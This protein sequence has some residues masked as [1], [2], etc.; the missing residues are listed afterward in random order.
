M[1]RNFLRFRVG[2][3]VACFAGCAAALASSNEIATVSNEVAA[4]TNEVVPVRYAVALHGDPKYPRGFK[5]FDYVNADA[6]KGGTLH[7][8]M[9]GTFDCL[10][11]FILRGR[12]APGL[13]L[14]YDTLFVSSGDEPYTVYGLIA[15]SMEFPKDR[16]WVI[17]N[18]RPEARWHDGAPITAEDVAFTFNVRREKGDPGFKFYYSS[19]SSVDVLGPRRVRFNIKPG[20]ASHEIPLFISQMPVLPKHYWEDRDFAA[21]TLE[22]PLASGPY[23]IKSFEVGRNIIYERVKD[24]W[25]KDLPVRRGIFNFDRV[26][27]IFFRDDTVM[28]EA[29][30]TG[31]YDWRLE[32]KAK[33]WVKGYE[34][35]ALKDGRIVK[36]LFPHHRAGVAYGLVFNTRREIFADRR[37]GRLSVMLSILSGPIKNFSTVL[38]TVCAAILI[39]PIWKPRGCRRGRNLSF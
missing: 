21:T 13:G 2:L 12:P 25:A 10:N 34:C 24:Y 31:V 16:S 22:P 33:N 18:L 35:E 28:L 26:H 14:G 27:Y 29:F 15:E 32:F 3:A 17:Y 37:C 6:P 8:G 38:I 5:H 7:L 30:K 36:K 1:M 19:V 11:P 20:E 23:K 39:I 4:V 9:S